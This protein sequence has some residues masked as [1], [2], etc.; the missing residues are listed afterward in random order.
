MKQLTPKVLWLVFVAVALACTTERKPSLQSA[1]SVAP[2]VVPLSSANYTFQAPDTVDAGWTTFKFANTGDDIHYAHIVQ[3]DS[4]RTV[5]DLV[6]GY[7]QAIRTSAPRPKWIKRFGGPGGAPPGGSAAV[8]QNLPPGSYVWICPIEDSAGN[9]HF[10]KGEAKAFVVRAATKPDG[11]ATSPV[12]TAVI[13]LMDFTFAVD[14]Q[15]KAG[16]HTIRVE[17]TGLEPHDLVMM[18]LA[19]GETLDDVR[20]FMNPERARRPG[21]ADRPPAPLKSLEN[22]GGGIAAIASGM[23]VFFEADLTPG[24]Y[25]LLCMATAPDGRAHI[26]HG[27]IQQ[28]HVQ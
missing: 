5:K 19:S 1:V 9:P 28:I 15:L 13:R 17:N 7:A 3:L 20:S 22:L 25:V 8:T 16:P 11:Q 14:S 27:M 24:E 12:A 10:G 26:E 6:E 21:K 2:R 18:K 4:G 23:H